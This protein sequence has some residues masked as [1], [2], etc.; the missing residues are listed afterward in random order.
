MIDERVEFWGTPVHMNLVSVELERPPGEGRAVEFV[1]VRMCGVGIA[2]R[3]RPSVGR[4][5]KKARLGGRRLSPP[6]LNPAKALYV[7]PVMYISITV[8]PIP[9][10]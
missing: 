10:Q 7:Q 5:I 8:L 6:E 2:R 1:V 3:K 4:K 9:L